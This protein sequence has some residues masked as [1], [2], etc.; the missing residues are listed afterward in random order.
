MQG[1][2]GVDYYTFWKSNRCTGPARVVP[3]TCSLRPF[4]VLLLW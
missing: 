3:D 2:H 4:T 1:V